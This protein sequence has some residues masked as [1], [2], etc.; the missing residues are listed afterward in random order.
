MKREPSTH[1]QAAKIIRAWLTTKGWPGKVRARTASMMTAVDVD[2]HADLTPAERK[3]AEEY[4]RQFAYGHFDGS[5]DS[6]RYSNTRTDI[7][8]VKYTNVTVYYSDEIKGRV[9]D[10][11]GTIGGIEPHLRDQYEWRA[12][13]G[14]WGD[15]WTSETAS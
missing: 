11:I 3:E 15:F 14:S 2:I 8:Q 12:L 1:A 4:V 6:Y 9:R 5:D 7:P 13:N 10:Y